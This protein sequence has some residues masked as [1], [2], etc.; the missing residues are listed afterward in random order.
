MQ[1][2]TVSL[3]DS[4][5]GIASGNQIIDFFLLKERKKKVNQS[6]R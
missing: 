2:R 5:L 3:L 6:S 1:I 4:L